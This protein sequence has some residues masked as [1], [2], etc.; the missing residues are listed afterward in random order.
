MEFM[1]NC[2]NT[3]TTPSPHQ[4]PPGGCMWF[5]TQPFNVHP[6][7]TMIQ[8]IW[9]PVPDMDVNDLK[10]AIRITQIVAA[11]SRATRAQVG[12]VVMHPGTRNII[13]H[14]Y[15]G[16]MAGDDNVMER[17]NTTLPHVVHAEVNALRK[18]PFW[19]AWRC[20][21]MITHAPCLSCAHLLH[22]RGVHH[23]YYQHNYGDGAGIT[24]L[25]A[26]GH[27]V[28]RVMLT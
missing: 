4:T 10:M 18:L 23:V 20:H 5:P 21:V 1:H 13:S 26:A 8:D 12:C 11:R 3:I 9:F 14:G 22:R 27:Q 28:K 7:T 6:V 17:D 2:S 24:W 16:T 25:R 19:G 15:N